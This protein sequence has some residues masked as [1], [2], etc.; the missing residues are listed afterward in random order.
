MAIEFEEHMSHSHQHR[1]SQNGGLLFRASATVGVDT[2][3]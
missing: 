1:N 2:A 3:V